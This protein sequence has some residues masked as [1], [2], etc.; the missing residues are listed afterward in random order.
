MG[1]SEEACSAGFST[2]VAV[3]SEYGLGLGLYNKFRVWARARAVQLGLV[4]GCT[5]SSSMG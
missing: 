2:L 4:L 1:S 5:V 3:S